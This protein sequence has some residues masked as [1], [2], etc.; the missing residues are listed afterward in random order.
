MQ[1]TLQISGKDMAGNSL[2]GG[3]VSN[4]WQFLSG[5]SLAPDLNTMYLPLIVKEN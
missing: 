2:D 5:F 4:P 3:N 1:Y